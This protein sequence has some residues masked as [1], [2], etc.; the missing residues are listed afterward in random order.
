MQ[1]YIQEGN[2]I[3]VTTPAGGYTSGEVV[4]VGDLVGVS[5]GTYVEGDTATVALKGVYSVPKSTG[6][7]TQGAPL[8]FDE[9]EGVVKTD[10]EAGANA[11]AGWAWEAALSADATVKIKLQL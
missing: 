4:K 3:E 2:V 11:L 8:Y 6:A 9:A 1:N 10:N 7:V 5:H